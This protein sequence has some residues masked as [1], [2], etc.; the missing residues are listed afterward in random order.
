MKIFKIFQFRY[1]H[2]KCIF[3]KFSK[4]FPKFSRKFRYNFKKSQN[5]LKN[6][7]TIINFSLI[8]N[9]FWKFSS[10]KKC[11]IFDFPNVQKYPPPLLPGP[12]SCINYRDVLGRLLRFPLLSFYQSI[13][14]DWG[15]WEKENYTRR[16]AVIR[17]RS[18]GRVSR[19]SCSSSDLIALKLIAL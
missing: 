12:P 6:F 7:Q 9:I 1:S 17:S 14:D 10:L 13:K 15:W 11:E 3:P 8:F 18:I 16:I 4:F 19:M 2:Y 5:F